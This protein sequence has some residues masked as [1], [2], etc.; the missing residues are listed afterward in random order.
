MGKQRRTTR[1]LGRLTTMVGVGLVLASLMLAAVGGV[2]GNVTAGVKKEDPTPTSTSTPSSF[3]PIEVKQK[4][5]KK[6]CSK[7][8]E[9]LLQ[10]RDHRVALRDQPDR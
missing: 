8:E 4:N 9:G 6:D 3:K 7:C 1:W 10:R 5:V 2:D